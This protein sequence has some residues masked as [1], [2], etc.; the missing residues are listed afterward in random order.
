MSTQAR[1][2]RIFREV[3]NDDSLALRDDMTN[4]DIAGWD[5]LAHINLMFSIESEFNVRFVGNQ[6]AELANIG[7]LKALLERAG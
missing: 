7:E 6:L 1:L 5:S 2:E 3:F 4:R